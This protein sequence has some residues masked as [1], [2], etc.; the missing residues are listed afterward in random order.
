MAS[1]RTHIDELVG[2]QPEDLVRDKLHPENGKS[3]EAADK[4]HEGGHAKLP[5]NI[6]PFSLKG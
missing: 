5:S 6:K 3:D 1:G 2:P 4:A